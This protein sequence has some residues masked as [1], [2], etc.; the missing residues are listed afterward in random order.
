VKLIRNF[1]LGGVLFASGAFASNLLTNG[2][3]ESGTFADNSGGCGAESLAP[4]S[5]AMTGWTVIA[6]TGPIAWLNTSNCYASGLNAENGT[7]FLDLTGITG[8]TTVG[9]VQQTT[10]LSLVAGNTYALT[11][12]LGYFGTGTTGAGGPVSVVASATN[13]NESLGQTFTAGMPGGGSAT[14]WTLETLSFTVVANAPVTIGLAGVYSAGHTFIGL[15]NVDLE[16]TGSGVPEPA[17]S[18]PL[19]LA[20]AF[21][22]L[23]RRKRAR[24]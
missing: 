21:F 16:L 18:I 23:S 3:F 14:N 15:D 10:S 6:G 8:D 17:M 12:Y 20:G 11:F 22:V 4:S 9:G 24:P 1:L 5:A 13:S 7:M 2:S 19:A